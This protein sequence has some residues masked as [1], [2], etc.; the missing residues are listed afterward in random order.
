MGWIVQYKF[1]S[2]LA[3]ES[4][5]RVGFRCEK[6]INVHL[7]LNCPYQRYWTPVSYTYT[8]ISTL[9][10]HSLSGATL[11]EV[12][13]V[14]VLFC[15]RPMCTVLAGVAC[16]WL[17]SGYA[18]EHLRYQ[19][20]DNVKTALTASRL[21]HRSTSHWQ[22]SFV[23]TGW[24]SKLLLTVSHR[25][26][27]YFTRDSFKPLRCDAIFNEDFSLQTYYRVWR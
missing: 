9:Y 11:E 24:P 25:A 27:N 23:S 17:K 5:S 16:R 4:G 21:Y 3:L 20:R 6:L 1:D 2:E 8:Y 26:V 12:W 19:S 18:T 22:R 13:T 7:Y 15:I 10:C 14:W